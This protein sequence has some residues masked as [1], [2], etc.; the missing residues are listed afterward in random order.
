MCVC[1]FGRSASRSKESGMADSQRQL[2]ELYQR[3]VQDEL[4]LEATIEENGDVLFEHPEMGGFFISL[5]VEVDPG[6]MKLAL[7]S[8]CDVSGFDREDIM[9][10]CNTVNV[11]KGQLATMTVHEAADGNICSSVT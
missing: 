11:G 7:P 2:A 6:Y 9:R 10:I 4:R 5:S 3:V 8:F 1:W